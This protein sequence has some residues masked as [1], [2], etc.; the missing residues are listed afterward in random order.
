[1]TDRP[2]KGGEEKVVVQVVL[3]ACNTAINPPNGI[4]FSFATLENSEE[5]A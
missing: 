3:A 1:M 5:Y 2:D 4:A